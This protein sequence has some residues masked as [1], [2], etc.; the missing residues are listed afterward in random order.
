MCGFCGAG[1]RLYSR[2]YDTVDDK[3]CITHNKEYTIIP[4]V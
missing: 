4:I 3:S 1:F 2:G